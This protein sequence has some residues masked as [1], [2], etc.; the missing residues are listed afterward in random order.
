MIVKLMLSLHFVML[1]LYHI[2]SM[3]LKVL[4]TKEGWDKVLA[5][6]LSLII[7]QDQWLR[8]LPR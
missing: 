6:Q 1:L 8:A 7:E 3:I 2:F 5:S 4:S